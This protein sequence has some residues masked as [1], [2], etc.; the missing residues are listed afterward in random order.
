MFWKEAWLR[1]A[2]ASSE[3]TSGPG[4]ERVSESHVW[5]ARVAPGEDPAGADPTWVCQTT[6]LPEMTR[7]LRWWDVRQ[8]V[9][10]VCSG[11]HSL[12]K[13]LKLQA[14]G[15]FRLLLRFGAARAHLIAAYDAF[16]RRRRGRPYPH[17]AGKIPLSQ[18]TPHHVLDLKPGETVAVKSLAEI[19]ATLNAQNRNRGMWFDQEMARFCGERHTVELRVERLIDEVTGK[20]L[21]MKNPCIQL[22]GVTCRGEC[23]ADRIGCPRGIN[24]YWREAWLQ[25]V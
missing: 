8:Y 20:M 14:F 17:V 18:P 12:V 21:V 22:Q 11:N 3:R 15:A 9:R 24:A 7:P 25:R 10:D 19:Q 2:D 23:T 4:L 16:Q 6:A 13:I 1:R 5:A